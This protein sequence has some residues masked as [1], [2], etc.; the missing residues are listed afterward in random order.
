MIPEIGGIRGFA[1]ATRHSKNT[2]VDGSR[3]QELIQK[4]LQLIFSE[5]SI[6]RE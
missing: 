6:L 3:L 4:K 1:R 2:I 5:I